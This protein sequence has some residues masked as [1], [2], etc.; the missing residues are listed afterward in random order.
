MR[1]AECP[2]PS[3]RA[4]SISTLCGGG[5]R[6]P[7]LR[8]YLL[9]PLCA[10]LTGVER[11]IESPAIVDVHRQSTRTNIV[12]NETTAKPSFRKAAKEC[13]PQK[14]ISSACL[15]RFLGGRRRGFC[16]DK[17]S[18]CSDA[19]S[20]GPLLADSEDRS[21]I[22]PL[23]PHRFQRKRLRPPERLTGRLC[24]RCSG[25]RRFQRPPGRCLRGQRAGPLARER[26]DEA[27]RRP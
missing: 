3:C 8:K 14:G 7:L 9:I 4:P 25:V 20:E 6:D 15:Y 16:N 27:L 18:E 2:F 23:R 1:D 24:R 19:S 21:T 13:P 26:T 17:T 12:K 10:C 22:R 11:I 5:H